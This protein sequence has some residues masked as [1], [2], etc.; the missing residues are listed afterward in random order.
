[1][2]A[3]FAVLTGDIIKSTSLDNSLLEQGLVALSDGAE[4]LSEWAQAPCHFSRAR[5]DGW[6]MVLAR[7]ALSLRACLFLR[8]ELRRH[9]RD[10]A[11][12]ISVAVGNGTIPESGDLNAAGG[13]AFLRS[14]R[15]LEAMKR[16]QQLAF[17][18]GENNGAVRAAF[19][20]ADALSRGWTEAQA[21][22]IAGLLH[23]DAPTQA[24]V[25][26]TLQIAKQAVQQVADATEFD[27][28]EAAL[29]AFEGNVDK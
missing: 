10:L 29:L 18:S 6:Q 14:G 3:P 28:V 25:A 13:D 19:H 2:S 1:M 22:A 21:A 9:G 15:G 20:L 17:D 23:P 5:G 4:Q 7:P 16:R 24:D 26:R 11:S 12:R 27:A 8:A